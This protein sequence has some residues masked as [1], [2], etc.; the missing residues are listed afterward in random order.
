M[1]QHETQFSTQKSQIQIG[2]K[3]LDFGCPFNTVVQQTSQ[4]EW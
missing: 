1:W 4:P 2:V 3:T